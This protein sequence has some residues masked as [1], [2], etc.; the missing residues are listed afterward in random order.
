MRSEIEQLKRQV[1]GLEYRNENLKYALMYALDN[2]IPK[3][4]IPVGVSNPYAW[5]IN[6]GHE[7]K[8]HGGK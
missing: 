6:R 8:K 1:Q 2:L 7:L 4:N 5:L 3:E